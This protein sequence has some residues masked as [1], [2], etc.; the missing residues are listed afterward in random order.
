VIDRI[1]IDKL[2]AK[3]QYKND[4]ASDTVRGKTE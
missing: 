2:I 3:E 1:E 4:I